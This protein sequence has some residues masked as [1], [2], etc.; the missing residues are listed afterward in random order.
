MDNDHTT[1]RSGVGL[2]HP[3]GDG[4]A[5]PAGARPV[6]KTLIGARVVLNLQV[7]HKEFAGLYGQVRK[8]IASRGVYV[9]ALDDDRVYEAA[10]ASVVTVWKP[11]PGG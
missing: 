6:D 10:P 5:W 9:I 7:R 2:T 8:A 4:S 3:R 1:G 11:C